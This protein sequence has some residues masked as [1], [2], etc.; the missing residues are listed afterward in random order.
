MR[1][2]A[3]GSPVR[4]VRGLTLLE[5]TVALAILAVVALGLISMIVSS[6]RL[7]DLAR[8]KSVASNAIRAYLEAMRA[9]TLT[10]VMN[11]KSTPCDFLVSDRALK[12]ATGEVFKINRE[13]GVGGVRVTGT[14]GSTGVNVPASAPF[15]DPGDRDDMSCLGFPPGGRDLDG[16]GK[17]TSNPVV[18]ASKLTVLPVRAQI[19]WTSAA[20]GTQSMV[21]YACLPSR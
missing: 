1:G 14:F 13:D 19:R 2:S 4:R 9:K 11:D 21:V 17:F 12:S 15:P 20:G 8:E 10:D 6:Q 3:F 16:D 18:D 5:V 7:T